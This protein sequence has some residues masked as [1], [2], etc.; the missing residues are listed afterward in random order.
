MLQLLGMQAGFW[1]RPGQIPDAARASPESVWADWPSAGEST[2]E[3]VETVPNSV[4]I[5]TR[6]TKVGLMLAKI[7]PVKKIWTRCR[8]SLG[9]Y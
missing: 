5:G 8:P 1:Q 6:L 7:G 3:F 2:Q 4:G 9:R